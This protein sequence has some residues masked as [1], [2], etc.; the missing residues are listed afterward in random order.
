MKP[1]PIIGLI[2]IVAI[3]V[4]WSY[5][6][7]ALT[8][9]ASIRA[10]LLAQTPVGSSMDE[11]RAFAQKR[12]WIGPAPQLQSYMIFRPR[13]SGVEVTSFSG[14]LWR[15]PFPYRTI[16]GAGWEFDSSNRLYDIRVTRFEFN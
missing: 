16:V 13:T 9:E 11:V 5:L 7:P 15:D 14:R 6:R 2:G 12:G 3:F 1:A 4:A 8:P 10:L